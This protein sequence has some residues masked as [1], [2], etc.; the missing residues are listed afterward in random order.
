M[1]SGGPSAVRDTDGIA[2]IAENVDRLA[3]SS[4]AF[5]APCDGMEEGNQEAFELCDIVGRYP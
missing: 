2:V 1:G 4:G 3:G 5:L